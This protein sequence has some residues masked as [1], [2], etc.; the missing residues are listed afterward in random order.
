MV[1][2]MAK[3]CCYPSCTEIVRDGLSGR[4]LKHR[5]AGK[6]IQ[7]KSTSTKIYKDKESRH[8]ANR[9]IY[10][11][12]RW[13]R[14]SLKKRT[15]TPFCEHCED[16]GIIKVADLVDHIQEIS[17]GGNPF[18]TSNLMSLCYQHH[19]QKTANEVRNRTTPFSSKPR[20]QDL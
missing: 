17:D 8:S 16:E 19:A 4:C 14:V 2:V 13:R 3:L 5:K 15:M 7:G 9:H 20:L 18:Q 6:T 10:D 12:A 1:I 11:S